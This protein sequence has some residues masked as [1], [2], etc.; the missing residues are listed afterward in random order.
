M[1]DES[2]YSSNN[3]PV[4]SQINGVLKEQKISED[5]I[6]AVKKTLDQGMIEN[7]SNQVLHEKERA[8]KLKE[9]FTENDINTM[10]PGLIFENIA[11]EYLTIKEE[12]PNRKLGELLLAICRNPHKFLSFVEQQITYEMVNS[13]SPAEKDRLIQEIR[14]VKKI[15]EKIPEHPSN[16]DAIALKLKQTE[17]DIEVTVTGSLE[18]KNYN[19]LSDI[20]NTEEVKDQLRKS[21]K[22][23]VS[24]LNQTIKYLPY[25]YIY[26]ERMGNKK[27]NYPNVSKVENEENFGQTIVQ[28]NLDFNDNDE[29]ENYIN[30]LKSFCSD[31][32][33]LEIDRKTLRKITGIISPLVKRKIYGRRDT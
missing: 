13:D 3:S 31:V 22:E 32:R 21:R 30:S 8:R 23:S 26:Y 4:Y 27:L 28:P 29:R 11:I 18:M 2:I 1:N 20:Q 33:F 10:I 6:N 15:K 9:P 14:N 25:Y 17:N 19:L 24:I 5:M 16:N 7:I 12:L